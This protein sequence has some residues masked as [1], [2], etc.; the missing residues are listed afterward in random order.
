MVLVEIFISLIIAHFY[1][2]FK[3]YEIGQEDEA[4]RLGYVKLDK[5]LKRM[6]I[7]LCTIFDIMSIV[8]FA[9]PKLVRDFLG[10]NYLATV[11]I[12]FLLLTFDNLVI[13]LLFTEASYNEEG[14]FVKKVFSKEKFYKYSEILSFTEIGNLKV[15]TQK[16]SFVLFNTMSGTDSLRKYLK[17]KNN[18]V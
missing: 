10:L 13:A 15:K 3:K 2:K 17:S 6:F 7:V 5:K 11:I 16:G 18:R 14:I 8:V 9:C 12:L 1:P 4:S